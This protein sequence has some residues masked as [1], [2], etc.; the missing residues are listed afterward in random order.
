MKYISLLKATYLNDIDEN[1][2]YNQR[3]NSQSTIHFSLPINNN[4]SFLCLDTYLFLLCEEIQV[5]NNK[6]ITRRNTND[7]IINYET[8]H[9]FIE[10][11]VLTNRIEGIVSTRKEINDLLNTNNPKV[12][13]RLYGMVNKYQNILNHDKIFKPIQSSL[14]LKK[15]YDEIL[16]QDIQNDNPHNLP[17]GLIFR[18]DHVDIVSSTKAI[19]SGLYPETKI[20]E[21]MDYALSILN[22]DTL[23]TLIKIAV[24]HYFLAYIHPWYDG[25]GRINRYVSSYYLS[26]LLDPHASLCLSIACKKNKKKYYEA[27]KTTNDIRNKGDLTFFVISFLEIYKD[28]LEDYL[29]TLNDQIDK[30]NYYLTKIQKEVKNQTT[31][32]ILKYILDYSLLKLCNISITELISLTNLSKSTISNRLKELENNNYIIRIK[33]SKQTTF[34]FNTE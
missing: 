32:L 6:I 28:G 20:I 19:H 14:D 13:K 26:N 10:E 23:P 7:S 30:Y 25:N 34:S 29:Q 33:E 1:K 3:F 27:F 21:A 5:L 24:F 12:Y 16:F 15:I 9:F 18:K 4:E 11:I 8:A 22:S 2:L 31:L 17:D